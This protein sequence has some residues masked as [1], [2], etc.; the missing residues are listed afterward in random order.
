MLWRIGIGAIV[1]AL[2][3]MTPVATRAG[4]SRCSPSQF[5]IQG[6]RGTIDSDVGYVYVTGTIINRCSEAAGVQVKITAYD[7]AGTVIDTTDE[8]PDSVSN[9][10]AGSSFPFKSMMRYQR[11]MKKFS[12]V[13]ISTQRW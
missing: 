5:K 3:F 13:P 8:W 6:T 2:C 11:G 12:V 9:I 10:P 7:S 1:M 4:S